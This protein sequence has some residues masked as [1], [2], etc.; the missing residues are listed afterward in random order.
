MLKFFLDFF[1]GYREVECAV[2][3]A[4][5][6]LDTIHKNK[7]K[8]RSLKKVNEKCVFTIND[9]YY[10]KLIK[11]LPDAEHV[12]SVKRERGLPHILK[13]YKKRP[14]LVVG[15]IIM[16]ML[17]KLS[18][19]FVWDISVEGNVNVSDAEILTAL[20]E[21]G[22]SVGSYIPGVDFYSICHK[23][24]LS[25]GNLSWVSVNMEGTEAKVVVI[26]NDIKGTPEYGNGSPSNLVA[27]FEGEIVRTES[28]SGQ[29]MVK[30]GDKVS[31]GQ[32]LISGV[33][34]VGQ[35]DTGIF[36]LVRSMGR[37]YA[38]TNRVFEISV[39]LENVKSVL[40][41]RKTVK[42]SF[43]FFGKSIKLKEN[44]SILLDGC[45]IITVNRRVVLF[46]GLGKSFEIPL[47]I[48]LQAVYTDV[49]EDVSVTYTEDEALAI[50]EKMM[51]QL[52]ANELSDAELLR[53][54]TNIDVVDGVLTLSLS[55]ECVQNI[56]TEAPIGLA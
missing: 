16:L 39:P 36:T 34:N 50:A 22:F 47:P 17:T 20:S 30:A 11:Y 52:L 26:E 25:N 55:I 3:D 14:G 35:G 43:K 29:V 49:Y 18:T 5:L 12:I 42:K 23:L 9:F 4:A 44:S 13:R 56:A 33:V 6:V 15:L 45:D 28:A 46:E 24:L 51:A 21:H 48:T 40:K 1:V 7:V 19:M 41:E 31:K 2:E 38:K 32:L 8:H 53:K 54:E 27:A 10:S 37:I